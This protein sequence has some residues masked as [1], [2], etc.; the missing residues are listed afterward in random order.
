MIPGNSPLPSCSMRKKL[1]RISCLTVLEV[2]PLSRSS[3][4]FVGRTL[5]GITQI[6]PCR[7]PDADL[8]ASLSAHQHC[9]VGATVTFGTAAPQILLHELGNGESASASTH[10]P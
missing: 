2:H 5:A 4:R 6:S 8:S 9:I 3:L 10:T 7:N 1:S